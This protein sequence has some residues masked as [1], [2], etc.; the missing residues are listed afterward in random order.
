MTKPFWEQ[1]Y[2][3]PATN[4]FGQPS[5]E[6]QQMVELLPPRASVLDLGCGEG[7][8]ALF[9]A[10][11]GF[12][13][14]AID[15]SV[16][17]I[18]KLRKLAEEAK[19]SICSEIADMRDYTFTTLYDLIIS[20][21]CL[22]LVERSVWFGLVQKIKQYTKPGGINVVVVF[23]DRLPPPDDLKD[24]CIGLFREGELAQLYAD[25]ETFLSKSYTFEDRHP[26]GFTHIHPANKVVMKKPSNEPL[27]WIAESAGSQ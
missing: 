1:T 11:K 25:W 9:L 15:I 3:D 7:R 27:H 2:T 18:R 14:T 24:F 13:V 6:I 17:G 8:N 20:H 21:G 10:N 19:V 5:E 4:T 22:H 12:D 16:A 23:T 26:G